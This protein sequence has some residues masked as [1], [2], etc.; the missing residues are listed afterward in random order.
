VIDEIE[1]G[2]RDS[3]KKGD[4]IMFDKQEEGKAK[5]WIHAKI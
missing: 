4:Q 2:H 1:T 3:G 5:Q